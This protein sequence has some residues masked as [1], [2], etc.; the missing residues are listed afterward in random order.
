M[1]DLKIDDRIQ[2]NLYNTH[3][4][5]DVSLSAPTPQFKTVKNLSHQE[6]KTMLNQLDGVWYS[7]YVQANNLTFAHKLFPKGVELKCNGGPVSQL[8]DQLGVKKIL[9][10]DVVKDAQ[11]ALYIPKPIDVWND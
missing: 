4:N 7:A 1:I 8:L 11:L 10:M 3:G 5:I 9:R 6:M 2:A